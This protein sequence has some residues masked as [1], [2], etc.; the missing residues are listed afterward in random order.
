MK[1]LEELGDVEKEILKS[2]K[3]GRS[4]GLT[5]PEIRDT[6]IKEGHTTTLKEVKEGVG[7]LIDYGS[8]RGYVN[9]SGDRTYYLS[10]GLGSGY[11][12]QTKLLGKP[13]LLLDTYKFFQRVFG[14]VFVLFGLGSIIFLSLSLTGKV[15]LAQMPSPVNAMFYLSFL[16]VLIGGA[17]LFIS[18]KN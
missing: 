16:L 10:R 7:E 3:S 6:L 5:T 18:S 15:I 8:V 9:R 12:N 17:L 2:L 4:R 1:R 14:V 11:R 13:N